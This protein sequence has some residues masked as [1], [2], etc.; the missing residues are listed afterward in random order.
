MRFAAMMPNFA[1]WPR[2]ATHGVHE[3]RS[4]PHQQVRS[5]QVHRLG[6][7]FGRLH[8][9]EAHGGA[10]GHFANRF[11]VVVV[12]LA[13]LHERLDVLRRDQ[14]HRMPQRLYNPGFSDG[15]CRTLRAPPQWARSWPGTSR[16]EPGCPVVSPPWIEAQGRDSLAASQPMNPEA[17]RHRDRGCAGRERNFWQGTPLPITMATRPQTPD[18]DPDADFTGGRGFYRRA[19]TGG[20]GL[21]RR[22]GTLPESGDFTGGP[23]RGLYRHA[24]RG[25]WR[26]ADSGNFDAIWHPY[27][28]HRRRR[29]APRRG[30]FTGGSLR[31]R[32]LSESVACPR[33]FTGDP[34]QPGES[35]PHAGRGLYRPD[36]GLYRR[37]VRRGSQPIQRGVRNCPGDFTG[38]P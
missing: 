6:L 27:A 4:L 13:A 34:A 7:G 25:L 3:L 28:R 2:M 20:R 23:G 37:G 8:R 5:T 24:G 21:Y 26:K 35:F 1:A 32:P 18:M 33:D 29:P 36:R 17:P 9:H 11:R 14:P 30:D 31:I 15:S 19:G 10:G 22:A 12:V 16:T 38:S